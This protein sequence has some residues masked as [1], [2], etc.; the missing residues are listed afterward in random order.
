MKLQGGLM[1]KEVTGDILLTKAEATAHGVAPN[2]DF[3]VGL[4]LSIRERWPALYKDFRH[5][6]HTQGPKP[7]E[8]FTWG[9][10][11]HTRIYNLL[12]QEPPQGHGD[13]PGKA[14]V[15]HVHH[16]LKALRKEIEKEGIKSIALPKLATG[17]GGL[18]WSDVKP[19]I[20]ETL[21]DLNTEVIV[22]S[23]YA[24]DQQAEE[25]L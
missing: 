2:D 6:C 23:T 17:V 8:M 5:F 25:G 4:A 1:I 16:A 15:K 20:E 21:G 11:E 18:D 24:K 7:G 19:L 10:A 12:T 9:G 14:K 22:Y 13:H 3:K